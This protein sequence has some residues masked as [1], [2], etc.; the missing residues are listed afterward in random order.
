[1]NHE[2]IEANVRSVAVGFTSL[3]FRSGWYERDGARRRR[4]AS[5]ST[6]DDRQD[7]ILRRF[8][9]YDQPLDPPPA[10]ILERVLPAVSAN[11]LTEPKSM[12]SG[13]SAHFK[14]LTTFAG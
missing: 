6:Y 3:V 2:E 5:A 14:A 8:D 10:P 4:L 13:M 11:M 9:T 1:M 7:E 12:L